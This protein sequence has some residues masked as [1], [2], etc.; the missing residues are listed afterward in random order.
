[1]KTK[2]QSTIVMVVLVAAVVAV[3]AW[4]KGWFSSGDNTVQ[5]STPPAPPNP[6]D[7]SQPPSIP[8]DYPTLPY[9]DR[10]TIGD[11]V[12]FTPAP[13]TQGEAFATIFR[14]YSGG[15]IPSFTTRD[16]N[17]VN[18]GAVVI[19]GLSP[20]EARIALD[21]AQ[22][23]NQ[24]AAFMQQPAALQIQG[25]MQRGGFPNFGLNEIK[26]SSNASSSGISVV[27]ASAPM[28]SPAAPSRGV[29]VP[30]KS[31]VSGFSSGYMGAQ[32]V[33][34]KSLAGR[35]ARDI[36]ASVSRVR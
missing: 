15:G 22:N 30:T 25:I 5:N 2:D 27:P 20:T 29:S 31:P 23:K 16:Q 26:P 12:G 9:T 1:M 21:R 33:A 13:R 18:S 10:V 35:S 11:R 6:E 34:A 32:A 24:P 3:Y 19:G 7:K 28:A 4:S 14:A 17:L 36:A 8:K